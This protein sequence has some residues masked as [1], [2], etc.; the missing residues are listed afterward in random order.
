MA[1]LLDPITWVNAQPRLPLFGLPP[2]DPGALGLLANARGPAPSLSPS[3]A[4]GSPRSLADYLAPPAPNWT[5]APIPVQPMPG[6]FMPGTPTPGQLNAGDPGRS[7]SDWTMTRLPPR[8][9]P[10]TIT[11]EQYKAAARYLAPNLTSLALG[12]ELPPPSLV[13]T[14]EGKLPSTE[15]PRRTGAAFEAADLASN[16][17]PPGLLEKAAIGGFKFLVPAFRRLLPEA[18]QL[19]KTRLPSNE[20][21]LNVRPLTPLE[22]IQLRRY[23]NAHGILGSVDPTN[24]LLSAFDRSRFLPHSWD[25]YTIEQEIARLKGLRVDPRP[26]S[27]EAER[28]LRALDE[29][30]N[31]DKD[32]AKYFKGI[33]LNPADFT[34]SLDAGWH[35]HLNT[36]PNRWAR[37][38]ADYLNKNRT[39]LTQEGVLDQL[40]KMMNQWHYIWS[41]P[42]QLPRQPPR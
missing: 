30:H 5:L 20:T 26:F 27:L 19:A 21:T 18:E 9:N 4:P 23:N 41:P 1:D 31:L 36:N 28:I 11:P 24:P 2:D 15:D 25:V 17:I 35:R 14:A 37:E 29:H 38:W 6:V 12:D 32:F 40:N 22:E 16:F 42:S 3:L 10:A 7:A 33:G 8:P 39:R 34:S 13:P